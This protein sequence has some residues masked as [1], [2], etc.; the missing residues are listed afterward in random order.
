ML[1]RMSQQTFRFNTLLPNS[2]RKLKVKTRGHPYKL[3]ATHLEHY[4]L[5]LHGLNFQISYEMIYICCLSCCQIQVNV[6]WLSRLL[7]DTINC[8]KCIP[9]KGLMTDNFFPICLG[10]NFCDVIEIGLKIPRKYLI[11]D[12]VYTY[13][14][15]VDPANIPT[16]YLTNIFTGYYLK[17]HLFWSQANVTR[18]F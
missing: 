11:R 8:S 15:H 13:T 16:W 3:V 12:T 4:C 18:Y 14:G 2:G 7:C 17:I 6:S 1:L 5:D 9:S 10:R